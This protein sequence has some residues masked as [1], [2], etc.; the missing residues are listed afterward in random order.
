MEN[1][2]PDTSFTINRSRL[3]RPTT[4]IKLTQEQLKQIST[5]DLATKQNLS[6]WNTMKT[7]QNYLKNI[8]SKTIISH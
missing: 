5:T 2:Y 3:T 4:K 1:T 7:T 6:T 8:E